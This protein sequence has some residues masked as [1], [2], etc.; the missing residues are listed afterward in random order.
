MVM[1]QISELLKREM[2]FR[3]GIDLRLQEVEVVFV[4]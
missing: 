3:I 4:L 2:T 1:I